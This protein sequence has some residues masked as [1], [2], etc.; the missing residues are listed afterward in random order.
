MKRIFI[1]LSIAFMLAA[2]G[3]SLKP[4]VNY[5]PDG[6]R[7]RPAFKNW[8]H[9]KFSWFGYRNPTAED[10]KKSQEQG[11]WGQDIPYIPAE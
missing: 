7:P 2:A 11:W 10:L 5:K 1:A 6:P 3:C 4:G 9:I 8:D